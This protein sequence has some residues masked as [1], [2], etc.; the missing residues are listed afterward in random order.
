MTNPRRAAVLVALAVALAGPV[1]PAAAL[2]AGDPAPALALPSASGTPWDLASLRGKV[3]YVDFWASWC[4]PCKRSFPWMNEIAAR[5]RDQGLEVV[6]VNVDRRRADAERFLAAVPARFAVV[7]DDSGR[8]PSGWQVAA[9]PS[10]YLVDA[11]GRVV[12]VERGF[13]DDRKAEVEARIRAAL[14]AR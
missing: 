13:R 12:M 7:F 8:T 1:P 2:S 5:Y 9:M 14:A 11:S 6:A 4:T 3:V 10:S